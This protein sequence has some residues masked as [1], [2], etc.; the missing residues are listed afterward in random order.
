M[1]EYLIL[2]YSFIDKSRSSA[3]GPPFWGIPLTRWRGYISFRS[4]YYGTLTASCLRPP[5]LT[6]YSYT[7]RISDLDPFLLHFFNNKLE[8]YSLINPLKVL[9]ISTTI[10]ADLSSKKSP[11]EVIPWQHVTVLCLKLMQW[12]GI[13]KWRLVSLYKQEIKHSYL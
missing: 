1:F 3:L 5:L 9:W 2:L 11:F 13:W 8:T 7:T 4:L 12:S 6:F 10:D